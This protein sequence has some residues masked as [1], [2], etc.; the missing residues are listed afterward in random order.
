MAGGRPTLRT[1]ELVQKISE[2]LVQGNSLA[3][4]CR[5]DDMPSYV[6]VW[7]WESE[8]PEFLNISLSARARGADFIADDI[9]RITDDL[10]I[11][12]QHK[13]IMVDARLRLIGKW[14]RKVYGEKVSQEVSGPDGAP[15]EFKGSEEELL[16]RIA[17]LAA[18]LTPEQLKAAGLKEAGLKE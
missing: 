14:N 13:R 9:I 3:S 11:D 2:L 7:K 6:T 16:A 12:P 1:P 17:T 18:T 15:I 5:R 8:D 10:D 4:I